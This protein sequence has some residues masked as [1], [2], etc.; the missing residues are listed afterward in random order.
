MTY[1]WQLIVGNIGTVLETNNGFMACLEYGQY[2]E[3]SKRSKGRA[4]GEN[5]TLL[6]NG[7][8]RYEYVGRL[9]Q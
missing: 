9:A 6:R 3:I 4:S 5:V 7:E 2:K 8:I 1:K